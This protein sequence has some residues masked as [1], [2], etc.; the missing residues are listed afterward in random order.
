M[1]SLKLFF[2]VLILVQ[3]VALAYLSIEGHKINW[4]AVSALLP[5]FVGYAT[6]RLS[7]AK[8]GKKLQNIR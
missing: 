3:L 5:S 6:L 2:G 4:A 7:M 8:D 1:K